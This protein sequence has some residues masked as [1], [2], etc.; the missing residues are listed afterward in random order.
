MGTYDH[1]GG[2]KVKLDAISADQERLFNA[3]DTNGDGFLSP[4]E[5]RRRGHL[6]ELFSTTSLF[7]LLDADG[8]G[9]LTAKEIGGPSRRWFA[10]YDA[11]NDGAIEA[12]ELPERRAGWRGRPPREDGA[13]DRP[14]SW[15]EHFL[16]TYD[17]DAD[18]KVTLGEIEEAQRRL[19][20]ALDGNRDG[21]V[22]P[23]EFRTGP[24][25]REIFAAASMF[26]LLD[27]DGGGDGKLS[28]DEIQG[29]TKRWFVRYDGNGDGVMTAEELPDRFRGRS[30]GRRR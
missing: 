18:G 4:D 9:K 6:L 13:G 1:D 11:N 26:D 29:P 14:K 7:D 21:W 24:R 10:R 15:S 12:G 8:D 22:T 25:A 23:E 28:L 17:A 30:E 2:G 19:F 5:F 20:A 27:T 3:I 16:R